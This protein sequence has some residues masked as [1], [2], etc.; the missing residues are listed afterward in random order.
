MKLFDNPASPFC[1]KVLVLAHETGQ[2]D[3]IEVMAAGGSPV[4]SDNMPKHINPLGKIPTLVTDD[5]KALFDSRVICQFL[6]ARSGGNFYPSST[7]FDTLAMEALGDGVMDAAVLMVYEARCREDAMQSSEW[8]EAQWAKVVRALDAL[9]ADL[10]GTAIDM[11]QI[12]VACALGYIDFRHDARSWRDG[13]P[14]LAAWF[15]EISKR[16]SMA[17][18]VPSA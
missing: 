17:A 1:R 15:E 7:R 6:D 18:T 13:R 4:A 16:P 14:N 5:G 12:S 9:E 2:L 11:G 8:V 3:Q 10:P